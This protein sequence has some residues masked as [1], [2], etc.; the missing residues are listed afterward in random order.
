MKFQAPTN[1]TGIFTRGVEYRADEN[2]VV[3]IDNDADAVTLAANGWQRLDDDE[4]AP[5]AAPPAD[6]SGDA[7][8][9][10]PAKKAAADDP[11]PAGDD[12]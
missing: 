3:E 8:T 10:K 11:P 12:A 6:E 2:G 9:G 1:V 5:A 4:A 7:P